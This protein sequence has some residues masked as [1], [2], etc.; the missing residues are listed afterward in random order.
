MVLVDSTTLTTS[1][2]HE[3]VDGRIQTA[4]SSWGMVMES[5]SAAE[6]WRGMLLE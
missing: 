5:F 2:P 3:L 6:P 4:A 1:R